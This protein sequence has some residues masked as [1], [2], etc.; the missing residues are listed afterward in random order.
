MIANTSND[1]DNTNIVVAQV[2]EN[3]ISTVCFTENSVVVAGDNCPICFDPITKNKNVCSTPCGHV[4]CFKCIV[5]CLNTSNTCP[6]CRSEINDSELYQDDDEDD[7]EDDDDDDDDDTFWSDY[8]DDEDEGDDENASERGEGEGEQG[9]DATTAVNT[10]ISSTED[11]EDECPI[12]QM[13]NHFKEKGVSY[14]ELMAVLFNRYPRGMTRRAKRRLEK[15]LYDMADFLD[16]EH[17]KQVSEN[18]A[19]MTH[20]HDYPGQGQVHGDKQEA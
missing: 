14:L 12:E 9:A 5:K 18:M 16:E 13:E 10:G 1:F 19:M 3:I 17:S 7:D 8:D 4:F 20:D 2:M 11:Y 6:F 15:N